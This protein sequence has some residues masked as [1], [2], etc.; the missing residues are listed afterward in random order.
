MTATLSPS[1]LACWLI[2]LY[3]RYLSP[4]KGF[5]CAY[6]VLRGRDSCS[7]FARRA[8]ERHGLPTGTRLLRRRF[9]R[10]RSASHVL[11]Y[12][13]AKRRQERRERGLW[14]ANRWNPGCNSPADAACCAGEGC[15]ELP[16]M[17]H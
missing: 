1:P 14:C 16:S 11:E 10:C 2:A 9:E 7:R 15:L 3:Q 13:R 17:F 12:D 8:I 4:R 5:R 6:G